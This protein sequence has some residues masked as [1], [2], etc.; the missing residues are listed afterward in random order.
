MAEVFGKNYAFLYDVFYKN[1][2]YKKEC[3]FLEDIFRKFLKVKPRKILDIACGTGNHA[4]AL[5]QMGYGL[6]GIDASKYMLKEARQKAKKK[7]LNAKYFKMRMEDFNFAIKFDAIISMFSTVNYLTDYDS[8]DTFLKN[9][10]G[11]LKKNAL[12]IFD[13]W[14]GVAVLNC[15]SPHKTKKIIYKDYIIERKSKTKLYPTDGLCRVDYKVN[16]FN[17]SQK[18]KKIFTESHMIRYFFIP[19]LKFLLKKCGFEVLKVFPFLNMDRKIRPNDWDIMV[20]AR[21]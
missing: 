4:N 14:S 16:V 12:F 5:A 10:R 7:S 3:I 15:Y 18:V 8:F 20:V 21:A 2:N 1:K 19:E 11:H 17:K 9:V 13:F 6:T